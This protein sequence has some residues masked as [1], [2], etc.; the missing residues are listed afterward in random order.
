MTD[1]AT[2]QA[3][4]RR[5]TKA[6]DQCSK[7]RRKCEGGTPACAGCIGQGKPEGCTY[8]KP[9]RRRGPAAGYSQTAR[10]A[11]ERV[12]LLQL[13][14]GDLLLLAPQIS[15]LVDYVVQ[16]RSTCSLVPTPQQQRQG[17]YGGGSYTPME[18]DARSSSTPVTTTHD[19]L[20][21]WAGGYDDGLSS[22][23]GTGGGG[24][25]GSTH[26][27]PTF[28]IPKWDDQD[29]V[30]K[31]LGVNGSP[32]SHQ[33]VEVEPYEIDLVGRWTGRGMIEGEWGGWV[34]QLRQ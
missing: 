18:T 14:L 31:F 9:A 26:E 5:V 4:R 11:T 19:I 28:E 21:T 12:R 30:L 8:S 25:G 16:R 29:E 23:F 34:E 2:P 6:C 20:P 15:D 27:L 17:E 3:K 24:R 10:S 7:R 22:I 13:I 32:V 33:L 1:D